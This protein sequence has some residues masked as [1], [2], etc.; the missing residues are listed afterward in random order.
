MDKQFVF[1]L[2]DKGKYSTGVL[3]LLFPFTGSRKLPCL[4]TKSL[5]PSFL[6][7]L[8]LFAFLLIGKDEWGCGGAG[9][10]RESGSQGLTPA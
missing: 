6:L 1:V 7:V 2:N 10:G 3:R 9:G 4:S 8:P 5:P